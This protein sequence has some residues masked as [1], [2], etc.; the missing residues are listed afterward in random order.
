MT[1]NPHPL[2]PPPMTAADFAAALNLDESTIERFVLYLDLLK[3]WQ[4][5]I[6]LVGASTLQDPWRRHFLDA[7]QLV[8]VIGP[9]SGPVYDIGS[10][11]GFPGVVLAMLGIADVH[12]VESDQRKATFLREALRTTGAAARIH[13]ERIE[14]IEG[15][16]GGAAVI[17]ARACAPLA[18]LL[19]ITQKI[20]R[21]DTIGLFL[22]GRNVDAELTVTKECWNIDVERLQSLSDPDGVILRIRTHIAAHD[23]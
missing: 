1:E 18:T 23:T 5:R 20:W 2:P 15:N 6:N 7:A 19:Q 8:K 13:A 17:T 10:G 12:L 22:K 21:S 16:G 14:S 3:K 9:T 4:K 11:A